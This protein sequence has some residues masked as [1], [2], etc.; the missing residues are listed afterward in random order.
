MSNKARYKSIKKLSI[1][2]VANPD[3]HFIAL[4]IEYYKENYTKFDKLFPFI[5]NKRL[6]SKVKKVEKGKKMRVVY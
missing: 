2:K 6:L 3:I 5:N 4:L 1:I